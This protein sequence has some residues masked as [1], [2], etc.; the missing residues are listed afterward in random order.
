MKAQCNYIP[1]SIWIKE[2]ENGIRHVT[3]R[4]NFS[5]EINIRYGENEK[6]YEYDESDV[7]IPERENIEQFINE[8]FA[9]LF[10]L[11]LQQ[12]EEN[13]SFE[14]KTNYTKNIIETGNL[15]DCIKIMGQQITNILLEVM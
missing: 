10:E 15:Y 13:A 7:F 1:D 12:M 14:E 4:R 5:E 6:V 11:G 3:L 9:N 8:N 2:V